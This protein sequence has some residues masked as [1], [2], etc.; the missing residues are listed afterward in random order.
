MVWTRRAIILMV[1]LPTQICGTHIT[2]PAQ[3]VR[4]TDG[5]HAPPVVRVVSR[6]ED[7]VPPVPRRS[8]CI[9]EKCKHCT[10]LLE[11]APQPIT[12]RNSLAAARGR[13]SALFMQTLSKAVTRKLSEGEPAALLLAEVERDHIQISFPAAGSQVY[14]LPPPCCQHL[15]NALIS[16]ITRMPFL[17]LTCSC[18]LIPLKW[19]GFLRFPSIEDKTQGAWKL[20]YTVD[21]AAMRVS[22]WYKG[23][24]VH[25]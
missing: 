24:T 4:R 2:C 5:T 25:W 20:M 15:G 22:P 17:S 16:G 8:S 6:G 23:S 13:P 18:K 12:L 14:L 10:A 3:G 7:A 21:Q 1:S 19:L 9:P 11:T